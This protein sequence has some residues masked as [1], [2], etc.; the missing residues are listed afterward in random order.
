VDEELHYLYA[1]PETKV[2]PPPVRTHAQL[3][4]FGD[5][6]WPDFERLCLRLADLESDVE[7][8]Q[9]YGVA[10]QAQ[11]GIDVY[12]RHKGGDY[13][14]YQ[15]R[16][17]E[18]FTASGIEKVVDDFLAGIWRDRAIELVLCTSADLSRTELAVAVEAGNERLR[19]IGKRFVPWDSNRLSTKLKELPQLVLDF[20]DRPWL[21]AFSP[22]AAGALTT[23]RRPT[24]PPLRRS[25]PCRAGRSPGARKRIEGK[26]R[27]NRRWSVFVERR[28]APGDRRGVDQRRRCL[29]V[30]EEA[31]EQA[32]ELVDRAQ[33]NLEEEAILPRDAMTLAD[34]WDRGG[35]LGNPR[36]L[37]GGGLDP[38]D[39]GQLVAE[40][41][42]VEFRAVAGD[43]ARPLQALDTLGDG[44]RG[45]AHAPAELCE[46]DAP[47][48]YQLADDLTVSSVDPRK[49]AVSGAC[50]SFL[51]GDRRA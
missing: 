44:R 43:D 49:I 4:P 37:A 29:A 6:S 11:E 15:C 18:S 38:D 51:H 14:V 32:A 40:P 17:V 16:R 19:S 5:L 8:A 39:R 9:L 24:R 26:R 33:M 7:H 22:E 35:K 47:V 31:V 12:A 3:L 13:T 46:R 36:Q 34:L 42:Q 20:F 10:G 45:Q 21:E 41:T 1:P 23:I 50:N 2:G 30:S 25:K 27:F 28:V 48:R